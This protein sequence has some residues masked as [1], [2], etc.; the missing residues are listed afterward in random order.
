MVNF[1]FTPLYRST[2]GFDR[3]PRLLQAARQFENTDLSYSP[4]NGGRPAKIHR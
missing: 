1:D 2:V 3:V 4:V